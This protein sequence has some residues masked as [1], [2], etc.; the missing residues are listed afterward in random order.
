MKKLLLLCSFLTLFAISHAQ[1]S[2]LWQLKSAR[3]THVTIPFKLV[4]NLIIVQ[5][6]VNESLP[7]NFI[8][9]T[10][11]KST[12]ITE[13]G[14]NDSITVNSA[15]KIMLQ[16]LGGENTI[17]ALQTRGNS[18][19]MPGVIANNQEVL[20]LMDNVFRL[21]EKLGMKINGL[22]GYELFKSFVVEINYIRK[23]I[24][25]Y[26]PEN[27][28]LP[29]KKFEKY[30][31][32]WYRFK[33][34]IDI[35]VKLSQQKDTSFFMH[36]LIDTGSSDALWIFKE[37]LNGFSVPE[38]NIESY[39]GRGLSGDIFGKKARIAGVEFGKMQLQTPIVA[40]PDSSELGIAL[41]YD[42]RNGSI[43]GEILKRYRIIFDYRHSRIALR[44]THL[45][46]KPF[47]FNMSGIELSN[48]YPGLPVFVVTDVREGSPGEEAGLLPG[49]QL[50]E[51]N[52]KHIDEYQLEEIQELFHKAIN[53][54]IKMKISRNGSPIW[55]NFILKATI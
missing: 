16:G 12:L 37:S 9:D 25:L 14:Y 51:I 43:G 17:E 8:L 53:R 23:L 38:P 20:V 36:M 27:Y 28:V 49:D 33:P 32:Y 48:P 34:Y 6:R 7:L 47:Y 13:I 3:K 50:L 19:Q 46:K 54:K 11:V 4:H 22:V 31:I 39:L 5:L 42:K 44:P 1:E 10:G 15:E 2:D 24:K 30:P 35:P 40:F 29:D 52:Y 21:S 45:S 55:V 26:R 18:I 41:Q